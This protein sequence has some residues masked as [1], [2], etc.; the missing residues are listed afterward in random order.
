[1][2]RIASILVAPTLLVGAA[3]PTEA[4]LREADVAF[5]GPSGI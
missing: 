5:G 1:M 3:T 4:T 2:K